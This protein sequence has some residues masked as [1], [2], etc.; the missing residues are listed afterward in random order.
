MFMKNL[1]FKLF[2][3]IV[4]PLCSVMASP[5]YEKEY[6]KEEF[7]TF[8][9]T[10]FEKYEFYKKLPLS[11]KNQKEEL[12]LKIEKDNLLSDK[13]EY[14][15]L[16]LEE[17]SI[18]LLNGIAHYIETQDQKEFQSL[19]IVLKNK[20]LTIE[21]TLNTY[22]IDLKKIK[23]K[24]IILN[25]YEHNLLNS[26]DNVLDKMYNIKHFINLIE[27]DTVGF[28]LKK[29]EILKS[30]NVENS[31]K[32]I[33]YNPIINE[34]NK[35]INIS[36][37]SVGRLILSG[38]YFITI[39]LISFL[40]YKVIKYLKVK[41]SLN[42]AIRSME[43]HSKY[44]I[45]IFIILALFTSSKI[46]IFPESLNDFYVHFLMSI[47]YLLF[48]V[49]IYNLIKDIASEKIRIFIDTKQEL[50]IEL[51]NL[52]I[53]F[54][55][56]TI[57]FIGFLLILN[58]FGINITYI[59]STLGFGS[60]AIAFAARETISNLFSGTVILLENNYSQGDFIEGANVE[61]NIVEIGL[62][63]T[64]IRTAENALVC[65]P[66]NELTTN[67]YKNWNKRKI[68][69]N[70][71][72]EIPL[73]YNNNIKN[74]KA[75][76]KEIKNYLENN[77]KIA[78]SQTSY[79]EEEKQLKIIS[80]EDQKGIKRNLNVYISNLNN[81]GITLTINC[82]TKTTNMEEWSEIKETLI[83]F[84]I[85]SLHKYNLDYMYSQQKILMEN[86]EETK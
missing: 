55:N 77:P 36:S 21:N 23:N 83:F 17:E 49:F 72:L 48:T 12:K 52:G 35:F 63:S 71:K 26:Y 16:I 46:L 45:A 59:L 29:K 50:R 22:V 13:L 61:G 11:K 15:N 31:I 47:I 78:N 54:S 38:I 32:V 73:H 3:L 30:L 5:F 2:F 27:Q 84:I 37:I 60:V 25:N 39:C 19:I 18:K 53:K 10:I 69:R 6:S 65:V 86:K 82:F 44:I 41:F 81:N 4:L 7:D 67:I 56:S 66:N 62:R 70:I 51:I 75:M 9:E 80:I 34:I 64:L 20:I 68:G 43:N 1:F 85:Q 74:L 58:E 42:L 57:F 33:D 28:K 8:K 76:I 40:Y 14:E 24:T 79:L